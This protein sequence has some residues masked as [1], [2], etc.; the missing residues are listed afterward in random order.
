M[1][2]ATGNIVKVKDSAP[3]PKQLPVIDQ[4]HAPTSNRVE[5]QAKSSVTKGEPVRTAS[6]E[7]LAELATASDELESATPQEILAWAVQR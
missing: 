7:L 2:V 5:I 4:A 6:P 1:S 3:S